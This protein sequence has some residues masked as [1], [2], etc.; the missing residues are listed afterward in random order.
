MAIYQFLTG[1]LRK[2][3]VVEFSMVKWIYVILGV[4][5]AALYA[6]VLAVSGWAW[7]I[8]S[9]IAGL[10]LILYTF[11][12]PGNMIEKSRQYIQNNTPMNQV[13]TL[14]SGVFF[15]IAAAVFFPILSSCAWWVYVV[16]IVVLIAKP[17]THLFL[18]K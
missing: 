15:G 1:K 8:V 16:L 18:M 17:F 7:L 2:F 5:I 12:F 9:F 6:P 3:T 11:T 10:P 14:L 4:L 13:L